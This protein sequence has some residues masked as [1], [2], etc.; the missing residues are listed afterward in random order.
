M[1]TIARRKRDYVHNMPPVGFH[2][3]VFRK[4]F[5]HLAT[6]DSNLHNT[7]Q[8]NKTRVYLYAKSENKVQ[9]EYVKWWPVDVSVSCALHVT[10]RYYNRV[11]F[12]IVSVK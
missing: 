12:K 10:C 3:Q 9:G 6:A 2:F 4:P 7:G 8:N 11:Y 5:Y 1:W